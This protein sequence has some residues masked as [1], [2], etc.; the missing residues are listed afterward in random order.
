MTRLLVV[1]ADGGSRGNPGPAA[2]GTVVRDGETG[3]VLVEVA[4]TI[5]EATNNVAEY[6]GVLAGIQHAL[7]VDPEARIEARLDSKL[8]VEQMSGRWA[9]KNAAL[10]ELALAV[11]RLG[12]DVSYTWVPRA[13]NTAADRLVNEALDAQSRGETVRIDRRVGAGLP[14]ADDVVG[15]AL[16]E[17]AEEARVAHRP[18]KVVGWATDLGTPTTT[19]LG[20]HGATPYS[21][22]KRF[23]GS[24]GADPALAPIGEQQAEALAREIAA[25]GGVDAIV[26]S[27]LLRTLQTAERVAHATGAAI[28][29]EPGIAECAFGE[30]DGFT[31]AEVN[32]RWPVELAAW[33]ASTDV[34]PP[35]GESF[36]ECRDRVDRVRRDLLTRHAGQRVAVISHVTPIKLMTGICVDAPLSSLYR[37]ELAPCSLTTIAWFADGNS[38]LFGF[39]ESA[40]LR[41]VDPG[42][43]V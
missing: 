32:E 12:G 13:Q 3:R 41:G 34:A 1:E 39:A 18:H 6:R 17:R 27:P 7:E 9:I 5:G 40:H 36:A 14:T 22:E 16:E 24:G 19:L 2:Y 42:F 37:M 30:W 33:L 15:D 38:S 26:S 43:G 28:D 21:L 31:F 11:R 29:I 25:R 10:R 20:R 23:S 8:I 4:E 35:G